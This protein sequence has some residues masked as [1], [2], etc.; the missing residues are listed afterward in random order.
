MDLGWLTVRVSEY[1]GAGK[2]SVIIISMCINNDVVIHEDALVI[3]L[4]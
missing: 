4:C 3:I 1:L 2:Q